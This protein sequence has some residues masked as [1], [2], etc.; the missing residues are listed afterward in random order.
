MMNSESSEEQVVV[1]QVSLGFLPIVRSREVL[2]P[3][4]VV[5][6]TLLPSR[7]ACRCADRGCKRPPT[8]RRDL[9][10]PCCCHRK[11][12]WVVLRS[13]FACS[14]C[15][16]MIRGSLR[17]TNCRSQPQSLSSFWYLGSDPFLELFSNQSREVIARC[18]TVDLLY[19]YLDHFQQAS[20]TWSLSV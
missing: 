1:L 20:G 2:Y 7:R 14:R 16:L 15:R 13:L 18:E 11:R 3:G 12:D 6:R 4:H 19:L 9:C 10:G 17:N 5:G 8:G